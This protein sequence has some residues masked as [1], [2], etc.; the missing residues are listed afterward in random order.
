MTRI[1][2]RKSPTV[3]ISPLL[4]TVAI[5][6]LASIAATISDAKAGASSGGDGP[7][8]GDSYMC[9]HPSTTVT[10]PAGVNCPGPGNTT[11]Q[12]QYTPCG[13][14]PPT[15]PPTCSGSQVAACMYPTIQ[16]SGSTSEMP[17]QWQ[18]IPASECTSYATLVPMATQP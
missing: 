12:V 17:P 10:C 18:C 9:L 14:T 1:H 13:F 4:A 2:A 16:V 8:A 3:R 6:G 7:L 5:C 15:T 11:T